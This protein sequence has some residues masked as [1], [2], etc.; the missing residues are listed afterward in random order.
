MDFNAFKQAVI[1]AAEA[2]GIT[3][4][5]L[6]FTSSDSLSVSAFGHVMEKYSSS[7][8]GGVCLRGLV[9]G[10][11]GYASTQALNAREALEIVDRAADNASILET[12]EPIF[13]GQGGQEYEVLDRKPY[14]LPTT[15][16][17]VSTVL[18][19]QEKLYAQDPSVVDGTETEGL[20][21]HTELY[22]YNSRGLI[23]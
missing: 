18:A 20:F 15:E 10:H 8:D 22:L 19:T 9:G 2:A 17:L 3:E 16:E 11:M 5:E 13:L 12:E 4:Y 14:P 23:S 6:Y 21:Q 1:A 7:V